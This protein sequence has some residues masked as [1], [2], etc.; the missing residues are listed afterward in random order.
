MRQVFFGT[1]VATT[2]LAAGLAWSDND[3][4]EAYELRQS[5]EILPLDTILERADIP[6][7]ARILEI[8]AEHEH[9]RRLY[10]IEYV[11][12]DGHITELKVDARTGEVLEREE[13]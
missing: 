8:E 11:S 9:G 10:E 6:R 1:V 5:R 3:H 4:E 2:A 13:D 7:E 12:S